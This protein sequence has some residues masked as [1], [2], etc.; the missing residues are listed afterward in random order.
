MLAKHPV[1]IFHS[2][3]IHQIAAGSFAI[4]PGSAF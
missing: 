1:R 2:T 3:D 4:C